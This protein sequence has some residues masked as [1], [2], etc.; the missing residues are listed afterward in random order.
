MKRYL[1]LFVGVDDVSMLKLLIKLF[2][3]RD[4]VLKIIKESVG[5]ELQ[6]YEKFQIQL[7]LRDIES[8][9]N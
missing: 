4:I 7:V 2:I 3:N 8:V 9:E 6:G 1:L 5:R